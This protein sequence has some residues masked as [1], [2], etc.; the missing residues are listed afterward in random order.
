VKRLII[1]TLI[2]VGTIG[3]A[4]AACTYNFDATQ[5][6]ISTVYPGFEKFPIVSGQST[7]LSLSATSKMYVAA[8]SQALQGKVNV[9]IP[10]QS[11]IFAYEYKF[12]VPS[13]LLPNSEQIMTY[14]NFAEGAYA[15]GK[16]QLIAMYTNHLQGSANPN[17]VAFI[18]GSTKDG[19]TG[20]LEIPV[21]NTADGY[22]Y[23]GFYVNQDTKQVGVIFN[24][25]NKGYI[26]N[27][28][29]KIQGLTFTNGYSYFG[30]DATSPNIGLSQSIELITDKT[31][32]KFLYP[33]GAKDICGNTI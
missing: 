22:Q 33:S 32:F 15:G 30:L 7:G 21:S 3:S 11:G 16:Y 28:V 24:G 31:K 10:P 27:H 5:A 8:N 20:L 14:P 1:G 4:F 17:S 18:V 26:S 6:E 9:I 25:I 2:S 19:S 23:I 29:D 12:K 13:V